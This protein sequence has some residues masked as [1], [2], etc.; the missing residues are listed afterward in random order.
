MFCRLQCLLEGGNNS[1]GLLVQRR[2]AEVFCRLPCPLEGGNN[3]AGLLVQ[4]RQVES[5]RTV[6]LTKCIGMAGKGAS[7]LLLDH[8]ADPSAL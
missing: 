8:L 6:L 2:Q 7:R 1:A 3:L 5:H 4:R